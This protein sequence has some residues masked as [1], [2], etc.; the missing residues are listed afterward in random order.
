MINFYSLTDQMQK[1]RWLIYFS[2][3]EMNVT[4]NGQNVTKIRQNVTK[5]GLGSDVE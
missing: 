2:F 5:I 4:K 1:K 3:D